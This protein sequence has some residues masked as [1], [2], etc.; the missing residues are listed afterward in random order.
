MIIDPALSA[1]P[2]CSWMYGFKNSWIIPFSF[3]CCWKLSA[4]YSFLL[5]DR[6]TVIL[7]CLIFPKS[8]KFFKSLKH[9]LFV[10]EKIHFL[11]LVHSTLNTRKYLVPRGDSIFTGPQ[12]SLCIFSP[13][14][15]L[16]FRFVDLCGFQVCFP[17]MHD[18]QKKSSSFSMT[19]SLKFINLL[20]FVRARIFRR[21]IRSC[22]SL[23]I[24]WIFSWATLHSVWGIITSNSI[25]SKLP[26]RIP[27]DETFPSRLCTSHLFSNAWEENCLS[28]MIVIEKRFFLKSALYN[29]LLTRRRVVRSC[30]KN[31]LL[32][33]TVY[34][35]FDSHASDS[36]DGQHFI[37]GSFAILTKCFFL[38]GFKE[39]K[40]SLCVPNGLFH[41]NHCSLPFILGRLSWFSYAIPHPFYPLFI[42]FLR[43]NLIRAQ[44]PC[45]FCT[46]SLG[47]LENLTR[48]SN[49]E[50]KF[51]FYAKNY[52][53]NA[54]QLLHKKL[55]RPVLCIKNDSARSTST[56]RSRLTTL[57]K[58]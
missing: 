7:F 50:P 3:R 19:K 23:F 4:V 48:W 1:L 46:F 29:T 56:Y 57:C 10:P 37:I 35:L 11:K 20:I 24:V 39:V 45:F 14:L 26:C 33:L 16:D 21:P 22:H 42:N 41:H 32:L 25:W 17:I 5:S 47:L 13:G 43:K 12:T 40:K 54:P 2:F 18:S 9:F 34:C 8:F 49:F 36:F 15:K 53:V 31:S 55:C 27:C 30:C 58:E 38:S 6:N 44:K 51:G 28:F 52:F